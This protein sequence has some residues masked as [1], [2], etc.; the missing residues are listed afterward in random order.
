[1]SLVSLRKKDLSEE[2]L[3]SFGIDIT[4]L[5]K[6]KFDPAT[7]TGAAED[8]RP[9][10]DRRPAPARLRRDDV[11]ARCGG[12]APA[13]GD[14]AR[15]R[16]PDR[17]AVVPEG[18]GPG[19]RAL[20]RHRDRRVAAA[21]RS[22]SSTRGWS[23]R[24]KVKVVYLGVPLDEFSRERGAAGDRRGAARTSARRRATSPIGTVTRLHDSKGNEYLVEAARLV[25]DV[26][27]EREVLPRRRRPAAAPASKRRRAGSALGDRFV[28]AGFARDVAA[29]LSA[30]DLSV[31]PSLWEGTPL[32]A[33]E[34][35]AAGKADRRHRRRRPA[36]HPDATI[37]TRASC[38]SANARA[39][40]D[41]IVA[42]MDEPA[43][44]AR[45]SRRRPGDRRQLRHRRVRAEDGTALRRCC[46]RCRAARTA[47]ACSSRTCRSWRGSGRR[48]PRGPRT[49]RPGPRADCRRRRARACTAGS[50]CRWISRAPPSAS[51]ATRPP[52][53]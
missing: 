30:F 18:G 27:P 24:A 1:M 38:R 39:L 40:A 12:D 46:T 35:L 15:A 44:R 28:F 50:R 34:A 25:L 10:A 45:L 49:A 41:Q 17:H 8:H 26:R 4:Y 53:T 16:E 52:T 29:A 5:H 22:S 20:H 9:Q 13:S 2:T 32:T 23:R 47:G 7:L 6:S 33:F 36:R 11:R 48:E 19:A 31:F 51:R 43:E 3:E 37:T 42:L 21:R 14:P